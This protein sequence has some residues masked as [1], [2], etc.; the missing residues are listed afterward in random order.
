MS[1]AIDL[2]GVLN[3]LPKYLLEGLAVGGAA[4]YLSKN[5]L[6]VNEVFS[7]GV[8]AALTFMI[9]DLWAPN[10]ASGTR[11][12]A[13]FGLGAM[14]AGFGLGEGFD[15]HQAD[16]GTTPLEEAVN[17]GPHLVNDQYARKAVRP[18]YSETVK[19]ANCDR[20][21]H[22]LPFNHRES[23]E[24]GFANPPM[25]NIDDPNKRRVPGAL[26]SGD[27]VNVTSDG[28]VLQRGTVNSQITFDKPLPEVMTNLAKLR[29]VLKDKHSGKQQKVI[30]YG[31]PVL[32][33][34]NSFVNNRNKSF[35]IKYGNRLQSHQEGPLFRVFKL[36]DAADQ[37]KKGPVKF[38][39]PMLIA[40]GDRSDDKVY[41]KIEADKSVTAGAVVAESDKMILSLNRVFEYGNRN[42]CVGPN[43]LLFP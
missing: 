19:A 43:E 14:L 27:L 5:R 1:Q 10:V 2:N 38:D 42:L 18:G 6:N 13:G 41:L 36:F 26:H 29:F 30:N 12:G 7:I 37:S 33:M 23:V 32:L 40:R 22:Y 25:G 4:K 17:P 9:L 21:S 31:D 15:D 35:V 28:R 24:E 20:L 34:H 11:Q 16:A 3:S 8:V 39:Q